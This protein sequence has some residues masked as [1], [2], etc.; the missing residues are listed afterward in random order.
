MKDKGESAFD[1]VVDESDT[2]S[3]ADEDSGTRGSEEIV[4][5]SEEVRDVSHSGAAFPFSKVEQRPLYVQEDTWNALEDARYYAEGALR[6]DFDIRN[7]ETRELDEALAQLICETVDADD[8]AERIVELRGF[9]PHST[10]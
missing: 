3:N 9:E 8:I 4:E 1:D 6:E 5:E 2:Q 10:D 7:V